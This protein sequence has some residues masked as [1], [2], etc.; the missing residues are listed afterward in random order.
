MENSSNWVSSKRTLN[1]SK[2]V[3]FSSNYLNEVQRW[4]M[5]NLIRKLLKMRE[6]LGITFYAISVKLEND[7]KKVKF[8]NGFYLGKHEK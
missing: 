8:L 2:R 6:I 1:Y 7:S 3:K 4:L 5:F